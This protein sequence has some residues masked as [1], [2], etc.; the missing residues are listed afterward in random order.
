MILC[1]VNVLLYA[2][3]QHSPHHSLCRR[4]LEGLLSGGLEM[5]CSELVL[6][7]VVRIATNPRIYQPPLSSGEAF[8]FVDV[9]RAHPDTRLIAPGPKHWQ[10]FQD[11]V[12]T[13]EIRGADTTDAYLAALAIEHGCEWWTTDRGFSRFPGLSWRW[14]LADSRSG[15]QL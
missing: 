11:L 6:A 1:D 4:E 12:L 2:T 7:A 9:L 8:A 13:G 10:I 14:L 5:A 3:M 15:M